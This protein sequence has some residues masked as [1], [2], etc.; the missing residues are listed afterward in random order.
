MTEGRIRKLTEFCIGL[1]FQ[2]CCRP[3]QH[4]SRYILGKSDTGPT[5]SYE[6]KNRT[7]LGHGHSRTACNLT[8]S[9]VRNLSRLSD[10]WECDVYSFDLVTPATVI[11]L[12]LRMYM[13][14]P[15]PQAAVKC[16]RE[17]D[18]MK[19]LYNAG[20]PVPQVFGC[21]TDPACLGAPFVI[22]KRICGPTLAQL[23]SGG[24]NED[25]QKVLDIFTS[26][27]VRL[28]HLDPADF[29]PATASLSTHSII[30]K[31][32]SEFER[33][34]LFLDDNVFGPALSWLEANMHQV[35][36]SRPSIIHYDFHAQNILV[37]DTSKHT[38]KKDEDCRPFCVGSQD[39]RQDDGQDKGQDEEQDDGIGKWQGVRQNDG[40]NKWQD[41]VFVI[42]WT[43]S[44]VS[45]FR[46]DLAWSLLLME[47]FE[48]QEMLKSYMNKMGVDN[49]SKSP[50]N[51]YGEPLTSSD[52]KST[53]DN[54]RQ[55][56]IDNGGQ[57]SIDNDGS[58]TYDSQ[59]NT[60][61]ACESGISDDLWPNSTNTSGRTV[62]D[63]D[64]FLVFA[65]V[66]RLASIYGSIKHGADRFGMRPGAEEIMKKQS[67][68]IRRLY[69]ILTN[70]SGLEL[71]E[72]ERW[73]AQVK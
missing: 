57:H 41:N 48:G 27:Y 36:P 62:E 13:D 6:T 53:P 72:L 17:F 29:D 12:I 44:R 4:S 28:H 14:K 43:Q 47:D 52:G 59:S 60:G 40:Q 56:C 3:S 34:R 39:Y 31:E 2:E 33:Y 16:Q 20:Y 35:K 10:G 68:H 25:R 50:A 67:K 38:L 37:G 19:H 9:N 32:F 51:N 1:S 66:R 22:M 54:C 11:P 58:S 46:F 18:V 21:E 5:T 30:R 73:V 70:K 61:N 49:D 65:C 71:P 42:D 8:G 7:Q 55:P 69:D 26:L 24:S 63:L 23:Y 15:E 64:Y 45:D